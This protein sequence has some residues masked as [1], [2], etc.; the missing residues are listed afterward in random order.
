MTPSHT[1]T[2]R[3]FLPCDACNIL[4]DRARCEESSRTPPLN[5]EKLDAYKA[6]TCK[7]C[8]S[9]KDKHVAS[10]LNNKTWYWCPK[11]GHPWASNTTIWREI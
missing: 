1:C 7:N 5:W 4:L 2:D 8:G 11:E 10:E 3:D 6:K 9:T